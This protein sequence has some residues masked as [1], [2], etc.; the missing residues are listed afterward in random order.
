V[1][2]RQPDG[3]IL[4]RAKFDCRLGVPP[5]D[6]VFELPPTLLLILGHPDTL[7]LPRG[8]ETTGGFGV[9][10]GATK[11]APILGRPLAEVLGTAEG[12]A[13]LLM[14][15]LDPIALGKVAV[16]LCTWVCGWL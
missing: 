8:L 3:S 13:M 12:I 5:A 14:L 2:P 15:G 9:L 11:L 4:G 7:G 16:P 1:V 10:F 6:I